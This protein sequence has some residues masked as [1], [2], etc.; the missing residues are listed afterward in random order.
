MGVTQQQPDP[1]IAFPDGEISHLNWYIDLCVRYAFFKGVMRVALGITNLTEGATSLKSSNQLDQAVQDK[2]PKPKFFTPTL[3]DRFKKGAWQFIRFWLALIMTASDLWVGYYVWTHSGP[4]YGVFAIACLLAVGAYIYWHDL[5]ERLPSIPGDILR[6]FPRTQRMTPLKWF[7]LAM[8]ATVMAASC[9]LSLYMLHTM[10]YSTF[11]LLAAR[12]G[13]SATAALGISVAIVI[14]TMMLFMALSFSDILHLANNFKKV[15]GWTGYWL[16]GYASE[17]GAKSQAGRNLLWKRM[18]R[19]VLRLGMGAAAIVLAW[20]F[21]GVMSATFF[22]GTGDFFASMGTAHPFWSPLSGLGSVPMA[23][24]TAVIFYFAL[25]GLMRVSVRLGNLIEK[26]AERG[27]SPVIDLCRTQGVWA[28]IRQGL[29]WLALTLRAVSF[30]QAVSALSDRGMGSG[31][32]QRG[33]DDVDVIG[34]RRN[35]LPGFIESADS[36]ARAAAAVHVKVIADDGQLRSEVA[37][38]SG[39]SVLVGSL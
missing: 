9:F 8:V 1:Q 33:S 39:Q 10:L 18:A 6:L 11:G 7:K 14:P 37:N 24:L 26:G 3:W 25:S 2:K 13:V 23:L 27:W 32:L 34:N 21:S 38:Q 22:N 19:A 4:A 29:A 36:F 15:G 17:I 28:T 35:A 20:T 16:I 31:L 12:W 5:G 30:G